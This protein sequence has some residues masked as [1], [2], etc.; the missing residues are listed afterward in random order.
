M[1]RLQMAWNSRI[2]LRVCATF[3]TVHHTNSFKYCFPPNNTQLPSARTPVLWF[4]FLKIVQVTGDVNNS[5][6]CVCCKNDSHALQQDVSIPNLPSLL[7][8][9]SVQ[10][11]LIS[12]ADE[13]GAGSQGNPGHHCRCCPCFYAVNS[14]KVHCG[15]DPLLFCVVFNRGWF[16]G[17]PGS[18]WPQLK[19]DRLCEG[20]WDPFTGC[21]VNRH[22]VSI[23]EAGHKLSVLHSKQ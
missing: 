7:S 9:R 2:S 23:C 10:R 17:A 3:F 20:D 11:E 6:R 21:S 4:R 12:A 5:W 22:P 18:L 14:S 8:C 13:T 19:E 16:P 15:F 1:G